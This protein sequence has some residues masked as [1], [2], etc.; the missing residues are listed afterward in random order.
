MTSAGLKMLP[1]QSDSNVCC[2][3]ARAAAKEL[4]LRQI[5]G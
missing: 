5:I 2:W 4:L 1:S 3:K